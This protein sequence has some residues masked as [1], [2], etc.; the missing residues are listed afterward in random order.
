MSVYE[1]M[2]VQ[3]LGRPCILGQLYNAAASEFVNKQF[4]LVDKV[5]TIVVPHQTEESFLKEVKSLEDRA[6]TLNISASLTINILGFSIGTYGSYL[7]RKEDYINSHTI[8]M[9]YRGRTRRE[10]INVQSV[11]DG[12]AM[13]HDDVKLAQA[14]HVVTA[15]TYGGNAVGTFTEKDTKHLART[16]SRGSFD[17]TLFK[18]LSNA[19]I[20]PYLGTSDR[21]K[22]NGHNLDIRLIA[23]FMDRQKD[24]PTNAIDLIT[25]VKKAKEKIG[26]GVPCDIILTPL[27]RFG[28]PSEFRELGDAEMKSLTSF[29]DQLIDLNAGRSYLLSYH[30]SNHGTIFPS[31]VAHCRTRSRAVEDLLR[32]AREELGDY[33]V[34]YRTG[35]ENKTV[36]AFI[37]QNRTTFTE[38]KQKFNDDI[39]QSNVLVNKF[40]T[41]MKHGFPFITASGLRAAMDKAIVVLVVVPGSVSHVKLLSV[42]RGLADDIRKWRASE[43]EKATKTTA[44]VASTTIYHS[45]YAD[46]QREDDFIFLDSSKNF[47]RASLA[48]VQQEKDATLLTFG[49]SLDSTGKPEWNTLNQEGWG[50]II[51][52]Q[53]RWR[54]VGA[55]HRGLQHGTGAITYRDGSSYSGGWYLGQREGLGELFSADTGVSIEKGIF[56]DNNLVHDGIVVDATIYRHDIPVDFAH[57]TLRLYESI[58]SHVGRIAKVFGWE[59][60]DKFRVSLVSPVATFRSIEF[61]VNGKRIDPSEDPDLAYSSWPLDAVGEKKIKVTVI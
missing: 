44:E 51:N 28:L 17:L 1:E 4:F 42:Y 55:V 27:S 32:R 19:F 47:I 21:E 50:I 59:L 36:D 45:I 40:G 43:D 60:G 54:Y 15:I 61:M 31:F 56:L 25:T 18:N 9:I 6:R 29:Y 10:Y 38:E 52:K 34:A 11:H 24:A 3:A 23:E 30:D 49:L 5:K 35:V 33:L 57:V 26:A 53:E 12:I 58:S 46:P 2:E 8:S 13:N 16:D 7:D 22:I 14:T 48:A 39:D 20:K 41:A 37:L